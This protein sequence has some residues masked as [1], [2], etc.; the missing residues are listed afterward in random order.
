VNSKPQIARL[1]PDF[2]SGLVVSV[3]LVRLSSKK[4]AYV[5]VDECCVVGNPEFAPSKITDFYFFRWTAGPSNTRDDKVQVA[6]PSFASGSAKSQYAQL[7][8]IHTL[9]YAEQGKTCAR[10]ARGKSDEYSAL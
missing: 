10:H 6:L 5:A 3:D 4:A 9:L 1:P 7:Q 2:L 8:V